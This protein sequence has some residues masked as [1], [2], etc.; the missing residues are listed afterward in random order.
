MAG[1]EGLQLKQGR[2][3][4]RGLHSMVRLEM[5]QWFGTR[6]WWVQILIWIAAVDAILFLVM[7]ISRSEGEAVP[8]SELLPLYSIFGGLSVAI[9]VCIIMQGAVVGEKSSGTAAWL[10]SKPITRAAFLTAKMLGNALALTVTAVLVPGLVAFA[11]ITL[12]SDPGPPLGA[13]LLGMV[14]LILSMLYWLSLTLLLGTLFNSRGPVIGIP[15][16]L[17]L[18]SQLILGVAPWIDNVIPYRLAFPFGEPE[19]PSVAQAVISGTLPES[20][21]PVIVAVVMVIAF[22]VAAILRFSREEL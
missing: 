2:G 13:F 6:R 14:V 7:L 21:Q 20:W 8:F 16:V 4:S 9:G 22:T 11:G 18:G 3:W 19:A 5:D 1:N 10:L 17:L 12:W 15:L